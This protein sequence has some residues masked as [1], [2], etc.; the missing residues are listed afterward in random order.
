MVAPVTKTRREHWRITV[1]LDAFLI[2]SLDAVRGQLHSP[3][4]L[5]Q[6]TGRT[7]GV[8]ANA[9]LEVPAPLTNRKKDPSVTVHTKLF[10]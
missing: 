4:I 6:G 8:D 5:P 3:V 10:I 7:E 1:K 2:P 9:G